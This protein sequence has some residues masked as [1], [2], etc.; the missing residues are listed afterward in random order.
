MMLILGSAKKENV[1]LATQYVALELK[2]RL[3]D[4]SVLKTN[5]EAE[6]H[7]N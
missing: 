3:L 1:R 2:S 6:T 5:Q 4:H 7:L